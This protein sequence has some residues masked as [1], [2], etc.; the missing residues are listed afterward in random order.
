MTTLR[1]NKISSKLYVLPLIAALLVNLTGITS[2]A[3]AAAEPDLLHKAYITSF[4]FGVVDVVDLTTNTV[5]KAK[6]HVGTNPN[7]AGFNPTGKQI[8]VTNRGSNSVSIIDPATDTVISTL[9][10]GL[11]PHG[12]AFNTDGSKAYVANQGGGSISVIDTGSL[13]VTNT[14]PVPGSP[15][16][17]VVIGNT[18]FVTAQGG[19]QVKIVDLIHEELVGDITVGNRPYGLSVNAAGTKIYTANQGS[20]SVSVIDVA[21]RSVEASIPVG[22]NPSATEV[23]RDGSR[24]YVANTFSNNISVIDTATHTVINT[25]PVGS[26]PYVIGLSSDGKNVYTINYGSNSMSVIDT[27]TMTVTAS[28]GLSS[29]PFMVGTFMVSTAAAAN[30]IPAQVAKPEASPASGAVPA[31]TGIS[32]SSTTPGATIYYTTDGSIPTVSSTVYSNPIIVTQAMTLQAIAV[33]NNMQDSEVMS[34]TYTLTAPKNST[35][36]PDAVSFDKRGDA[37][38]DIIT[39]LTLNDNTL[40][41]IH[42]AD[43]PLLPGTDYTVDGDTVTISKAYL[44]K[45]AVGTTQLTFTFNAGAV[46]TLVI[47]VVD[48]TPPKVLGAPVLESAV[49]GNAKVQ[50]TWSPVEGSTGYKVYQS[51][52]SDT[53]GT[54]LNTVQ[55]SVYTYNA[56]GLT[57][58]TTYYYVVKAVNSA[59]DSLAS[60]QAS[61]TP[62]TVP[63]A[64]S[65]VSAVAGNGQATITFASPADNGGSP[66]T[67]FEVSSS[68]GGF[69]A[70]SVMSPVTIT[71]LQNGTVYTFTVKAINA[72]GSSIDSAPSNSVTPAAPVTAPAPTAAAADPGASVLING[73]IQ[74]IGQITLKQINNQAAA[75][76]SVNE[77][78]LEEQLNT[79][80]PG[81]VITF[82]FT[83]TAGI[84]IGELNGRIVKNLEQHQAVIKIQTP[85]ASYTLPAQQIQMDNIANQ[86]WQTAELQNVKVQIQI[87]TPAPDQMKIIDNAAA[88]GNFTIAAAPLDFTIHATSGDRTVEVNSFNSY[89]ERTI[90]LAGGV[91]TSKITTALVIEADGSVRHVPTKIENNN[92]VLY[93]KINSRTN[94][95]YAV[96]YHPVSFADV[97]NHWS[98]DVV[99]DLGSRMVI[100]GVDGTAFYPNQDMT[101]A[102]FAATLVRALGLKLQDGAASFTD[103]QSSAWYHDEILTAAK[104]NLVQGYEDHSFRPLDK[105]T[106][107]QAMTMIAKAMALTPAIAQ[108]TDVSLS[109]FR[110]ADQVSAWAAASVN[111]SLKAGIVTGR[112]QDILAPKASVTRAEVAAMIHR[113]LQKSDLI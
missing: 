62:A 40:T 65:E 47:T 26:N 94:S 74:S 44:A 43:E 32:L 109:S 97:A 108:S 27:D 98:Q 102:E 37:E 45:Q 10:V 24:V 16:A 52:S 82:P 70:S 93:A 22:D 83:Q 67:G 59:G 15:T 2:P 104:Y 35:I 77:A 61:A 13:T 60:N 17:M 48:T 110:D 4:N 9:P 6:I 95:T 39:T 105:V 55:A 11:A 63:G 41:S 64:P 49:P 103:V 36:N 46:Q 90:Q 8:F 101:R 5:E 14:I 80:G 56:T 88:A 7:S 66:I 18:L 38:A 21:S 92:G 31:G 42:N 28:P 58:G 72:V 79:A 100:N 1:K 57:N 106:R 30:P 23:S 73:K 84:L 112:S 12:V 53:Y 25:V 113:F 29:G 81:A 85:Q 107:E 76:L 86:L 99:N 19:S 50:L 68:A 3:S 78:K 71:G 34:E 69:K 87:S 89:V 75:I 20:N 51:V 54:E 33:K 96:V 91:D 111:G